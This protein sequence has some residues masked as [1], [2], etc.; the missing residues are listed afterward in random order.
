M[1]LCAR[2]REQYSGISQGDH[3]LELQDYL[4][5]LR[6]RWIAILLITA[7]AV[8][9]AG[10]VT[11]LTTPLYESRAQVYVSVRTSSESTSDLLQGSNFTQ[12][13]IKSYVDLT[14][15]PRVLQPVIE[16]LGLD[17]TADQLAGAINANTPLD[18]S[19]I[20]ITASDPD[21]QRAA[22]IANATA[23]SLAVQVTELERPESGESPVQVSTVRVATPS[24][25]PA[26]PNTQLNLALGLLVGLAL[27]VGYAVLREVLDTRVRTANDIARVTEAA[28]V[29]TVA[30]DAEASKHPLIV[31]TDPHSQ[32]AEAFRR[33]RTN[34][35]FL[36]VDSRPRLIV[37][38]SSLPDEGKSTTA[39]NL[40]ITLADAGARVALVDADLRDP[41]VSRYMGLEGAVGLTTV[42]IGRAELA[43][44]LQPWGEGTLDVLPAGQVPPNPS[45]LLGSGAMSQVLDAL[46]RAYDTVVLDSAPLLP[47]TDGAVLARLAGGAVVVARAGE[48]TRTQLGDAIAS[49][50]SVGTPVHGIV[51]N[52][53]AQKSGDSYS[54]YRYAPQLESGHSGHNRPG[55]PSMRRHSSPRTENSGRKR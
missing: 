41:S 40:A 26:S 45:E 46:T 35:Q 39:I 52:A 16:E 54:Y 51:L 5:I 4:A 15:S 21:A 14:G 55:R 42:L 3:V 29:G 36:G 33:L 30:F 31:Q 6:K 27:G 34:L 43:D 13:Q 17:E 10:V 1:L 32:R 18:T 47:V 48:V 9:G 11:Y 49:L 23:E 53:V 37:V 38:T 24:S 7:L 50:E 22:D 20:N 44:V 25:S 28:V 19:L 12:R 8:V 2:W